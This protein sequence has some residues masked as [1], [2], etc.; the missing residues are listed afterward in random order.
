MKTCVLFFL[1]FLDEKLLN[2]KKH[3]KIDESGKTL[4][5]EVFVF[6]LRRVVCRYDR[7][8]GCTMPVGRNLR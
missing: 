1:R 3:E 4:S 8:D 2:W 7:C 6:I 5:L